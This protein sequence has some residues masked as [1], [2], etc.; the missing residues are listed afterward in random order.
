[1]L[2][3]WCSRNTLVPQELDKGAASPAIGQG[4]FCF[5]S[6]VQFYRHPCCLSAL[7]RGGMGPESLKDVVGDVSITFVFKMLIK[8]VK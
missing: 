5:R 8:F 1:M 2:V 3:R 7:M 6:T 4:T